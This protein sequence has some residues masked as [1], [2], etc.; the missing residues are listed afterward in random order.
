MTT[1]AETRSFPF[2]WTNLGDPAP[3]YAELREREPVAPIV[4]P[5]GHRGWV[6]SRYETVR[7]VVSDLRFSK[8]AATL[9]GAPLLV[10]VF[11][12]LRSM[13]V[14]DPPNHTRL[15]KLVVRA[16]SASRVERLRTWI[17][18]RC[19]LLVGEL[20]AGPNPADVVEKVALPLPI[21]TIC[22]L[23]GVPEP[24]WDQFREWG[25]LAIG[26]VNKSGGGAEEPKAAGRAL[27]AYLGEL[28]HLKQAEP[29]D[30]LL[31]AL[32][33]VHDEGDRLSTEEFCG[34]GMT[35]LLGG[36][37]TTSSGIAQMITHL[38]RARE[39]F[40]AVIA[41]HGLINSTVE[42]MLRYAQVSNGLGALRVA[43]EDVEVEGVLIRK[44]EPVIPA[45]GSANRD[46]RAFDE[47]DSIDLARADNKHLSFG[48]GIHYCVGGQLARAEMQELLGV[49]V[50]MAPELNLAAPETEPAWLFPFF[51]RPADLYVTW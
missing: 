25:D 27:M 10:P 49:I 14:L 32:T 3:E 9:P 4:L 34:V 26:V 6:V 41:D 8:E 35:L 43:L 40:E 7:F 39:R 19:E 15:R 38:L 17:R 20:L 51:P 30:D 21:V 33:Q 50:R 2:S 24:D 29:R 1:E 28:M 18:D 5:T 23:L 12:G 31:T 11:E 47:P 48:A 37:H 13:I 46:W 22:E 45:F 36:Y 42:E 44:G 16:F